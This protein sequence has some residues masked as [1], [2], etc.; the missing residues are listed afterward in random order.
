MGAILQTKSLAEAT[1]AKSLSFW[2]PWLIVGALLLGLYGQV[3]V[4]LADDWWSEPKASHG[5]LVPPLAAYVAWKRKHVTLSIP[6]APDFRG[7][8]LI[9]GSCLVLL[10]GKLGAE[11]FLSRISLVLLLAGFVYTFW[12]RQRLNTLAFPLLL[13]ATMVPLPVIVYNQLAQPLQLFASEVSTKVAQFFGVSVYTEGNVIQ[14]ATTTLGVEEACSGLRSLAAL[15]VMALLLGFVVCRRPAVR[16]V[17]LM[18]AFPIAVLVNVIRVAGTAVLADRNP[19]L[20][21]GFYHT[22]SGWLIFLVGVG[23]VFGACQ[24]L[25]RF[26]DRAA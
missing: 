2:I 11:Y 5:L 19:D 8:F 9:A 22:F 15:V 26:V 16:I 6:A 14:L 21:M 12:G 3:V 20:A 7:L 13:L 1:E 24:L 25:H 17:L 10:I 23:L 4:G 18:L